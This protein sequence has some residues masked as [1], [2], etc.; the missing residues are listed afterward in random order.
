MWF[1]FEYFDLVDF[2]EVGVVGDY[3][4]VIGVLGWLVV[5]GDV[6]VD[7]VEEVFVGFDGWGYC[8]FGCVFDWVVFFCG[9]GVVG[10]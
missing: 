5:V 1:G 7:F 4:G 6:F 3:F 10:G 8:G 9:Y 2:G